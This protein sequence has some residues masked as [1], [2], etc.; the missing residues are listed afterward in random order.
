[1]EDARCEWCHHSE[2][3]G[4]FM[5]CSKSNAEVSRNHACS[6]YEREPG[7]DDNKHDE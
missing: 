4:G 3:A 7:A 1:M 6:E 2:Y 5:A